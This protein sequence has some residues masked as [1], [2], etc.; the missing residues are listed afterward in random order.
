MD[1][2]EIVAAMVTV[3][4]TLLG[5]IAAALL[6]WRNET[7]RRREDRH[8]ELSSAALAAL[9]ALVR[10]TINIAYADLPPRSRDH[11]DSAAQ[12]ELRKAYETTVTVWNSAMYAVLVGSDEQAARGVR[13]IDLEID[14]LTDLA[15]SKRWE[16]VDFR[17][18]RRRLGTLMANHIDTA[19]REANLP[20]LDLRTVWTW[21]VEEDGPSTPGPSEGTRSGLGRSSR[22]GSDPTR[23]VEPG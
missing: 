4:V 8:L 7:R 9:Q 6:A 23:S 22:P 16:R 1:G 18:Q 2:G 17:E 14:R 3:A 20:P 13:E 12:A 5:V 21:A 19:R 10:A 11:M 15:L